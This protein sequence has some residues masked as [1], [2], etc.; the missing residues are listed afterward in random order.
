VALGDALLGEARVQSR[1]GNEREAKSFASQ[2]VA[3]YRKGGSVSGERDAWLGMAEVE[4]S[5]GN[6]E[7]AVSAAREAV[8]LH[9]VWRSKKISET[10]RAQEDESISAA[11]DVLVPV[12][13]S[14][15]QT[16]QALAAA[17]EARSH[18]LLDFLAAGFKHG[19]QG[20]A[21]DL[22]A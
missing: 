18:V 17:E 5:S 19:K 2:A 10:Q 6:L 22:R 8:R 1:L 16:E 15:A 4:H 11:Y 21:V 12:L 20:V 13:L 7:P 9:A 3:A 14:Q